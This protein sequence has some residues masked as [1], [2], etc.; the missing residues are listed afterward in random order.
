MFN[1]EEGGSSRALQ[2][3]PFYSKKKCIRAFVSWLL[4]ATFAIDIGLFS[5]LHKRV[6]EALIKQSSKGI[7]LVF[8]II[9]LFSFK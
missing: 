4:A 5:V 7:M 9:L 8:H 1:T 2:L 6:V 3:K